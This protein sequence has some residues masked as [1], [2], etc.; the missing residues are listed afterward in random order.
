MPGKSHQNSKKPR[1][2]SQKSRR[3]VFFEKA[4]RFTYFTENIKDL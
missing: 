2:P 3:K 4:R 1:L